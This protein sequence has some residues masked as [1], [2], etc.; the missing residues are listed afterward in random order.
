M[1]LLPSIA[2]P[3]VLHKLW[4]MVFPNTSTKYKN[5]DLKINKNLNTLGIVR[6]Y[7]YVASWIHYL[8][9]HSRSLKIWAINWIF[10]TSQRNKLGPNWKVQKQNYT[11]IQNNFGKFKSHP[12]NRFDPKKR[13]NGLPY[14]C[15]IN[16]LNSRLQHKQIHIYIFTIFRDS[17]FHIRQAKYNQ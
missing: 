7:I 6:S 4:K 5:L 10:R 2:N 13:K 1:K 16:S 14:I 11:T 15:T 3:N 9:I 17:W 8:L 12:Y